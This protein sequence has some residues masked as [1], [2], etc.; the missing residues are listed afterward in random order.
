M[1][2]FFTREMKNW[3]FI[4][5]WSFYAGGRYSR[6]NCILSSFLLNALSNN[7]SIFFFLYLQWIEPGPGRAELLEQSQMARDVR[8]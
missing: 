1:R 3:V 5:R 2:T 7:P 6:F 4:D 8:C